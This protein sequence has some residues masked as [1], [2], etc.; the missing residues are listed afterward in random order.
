MAVTALFFAATSSKEGTEASKSIEPVLVR[1]LLCPNTLK[2]RKSSAIN[3]NFF[4]L[5]YLDFH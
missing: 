1:Y 3:D 4:L 2:Y 5:I